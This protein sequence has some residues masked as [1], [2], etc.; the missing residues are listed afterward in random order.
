MK[1]RYTN[2]SVSFDLKRL[3]RIDKYVEDNGGS[4]SKFIRDAVDAYLDHN[5][6]VS[7]VSIQDSTPEPTK[8]SIEDTP[9]TNKNDFNFDDI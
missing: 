6:T 8:Q 2:V 4:F 3:S 9:K 1:K 5:Q 7:N